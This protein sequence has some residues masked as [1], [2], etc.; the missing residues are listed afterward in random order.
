MTGKVE[1]LNEMSDDEAKAVF[2]GGGVTL[3]YFKEMGAHPA[4]T[5]LKAT[6]KPLLVMQGSR[7]FQVNAEKDFNLYKE[8]LEGKDATF[9][10][11]EGLNHVFVPAVTDDIMKLKQEYGKER[12]IGAEVF[13]DI[14]EWMKRY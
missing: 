7:D 12:H 3:Y 4:E 10:L 11:Y 1:G 5:Y 6:D 2:F 9:V 14:A 8:I 13:D